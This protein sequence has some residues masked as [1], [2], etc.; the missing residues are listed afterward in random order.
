MRS[1][2]LA[3]QLYLTIWESYITILFRSAH[4]SRRASLYPWFYVPAAFLVF[5]T[6]LAVGQVS[7]A[8]AQQRWYDDMSSHWAETYV[9]VLWEEQVADGWFYSYQLW[10]EYEVRPYTLERNYFYPEEFI[11]RGQYAVM[12]SKVFRLS[13]YDK[14]VPSYQDVPPSYTEYGRLSAYPYIEAARL[15]NLIPAGEYMYPARTL[16]REEAIAGLV[17]GLGLSSYAETLSEAE[18]S[19]V[20]AGFYDGSATSPQLRRQVAAAIKLRIVHGYPDRTLRPVSPLKR[21]EAATLLFRSCLFVIDASP[22]PFSPD[23]DTIDDYTVLTTDTLKN[24]NLTDWNILIVHFQGYPLRTFR[25]GYF[26]GTPDCPPPISWDGRDDNGER[27]P[28]GTY[29]YRGWGRDRQGIVY[30]AVM[31]PIVI[32]EKRLQGSLFPFSVKPGRL[33]HVSA[34]TTGGAVQVR[35][36]PRFESLDYVSISPFPSGQSVSVSLQTAASYSLALTGQNPAGGTSTR[37]DITYTVPQSAA[38][39]LYTFRLAAVYP[40]TTRGLNLYFQVVDHIDL[41]G[42]L[43]PNPALPGQFVAIS[44]WTGTNVSALRAAVPGG[45]VID[46]QRKAHEPAPGGEDYVRAWSGAWLIPADTVPGSYDVIL[47]AIGNTRTRS[48]TLPL[49]VL[50]HPLSRVTFVLTD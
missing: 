4:R 15:A 49:L 38:E 32:E 28:A 9:R 18:V 50:E 31:K 29:Y 48:I 24:R 12:L 44:A 25:P 45:E 20:L 11:T 34:H 14:L 1:A 3:R 46:L 7:P 30:E 42:L 47:T 33:L 39:G 5:I 43:E 41:S 21:S 35:G 37:W 6:A 23:G 26:S 16:S 17:H 40:G 27:L 2:R 8:L 10:D 13:P 19:F 22:N 36:E